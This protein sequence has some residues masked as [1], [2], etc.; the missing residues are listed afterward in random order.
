MGNLL[1]FAASEAETFTFDFDMVDNTLFLVRRESSPTLKIPGIRGYGHTFPEAYTSW[2]A[3]V[4][5]S[6]SHQRIVRYDFGT[7]RCLV[8]SESDGL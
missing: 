8:R 7:L 5:G 3:A 6:A 4:K 2:T 1:R